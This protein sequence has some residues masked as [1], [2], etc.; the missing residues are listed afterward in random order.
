MSLCGSRGLFTAAAA[1]L[2]SLLLISTASAAP[3]LALGY[4]PKYNADFSHF[5]Y[6]DPAAVK[7]GGVTLGSFGSFDSLN[8]FILKGMAADGLNQLLF[9]TLMEQSLDEPFSQYGL[10]AEDVVLA[11]DRLSV[12]FRLRAEAQFSDGS[13]VTAEDVKFSFDTLKSDQAH[14]QYR[15]Y[16]ADIAAAE[17]ID[18]RTVRFKFTQVNP[19]L[20]LL[21]GQIP[22]FSRRWVGERDFS[23]LA[24]VEPIASGPYRVESFIIGKQITYRR[25]PN[26]W[27][28]D[29]PVRRGLYN[30]DTVQYKYYRDE[31]VALEAFK[32]GEFEFNL[33]SNSKKWATDYTGPRFSSGEI[34]LEEVAHHN[35]AG[36]QGFIFNLRKP[37]FQDQRVRQAIGLALDFEW[38]NQNLFYNQYQRCNSY[39]SNSD[40]AATE[41]PTAAELKL[42]E[43]FKSQLPAALFT[44]P[45]QPPTTTGVGGLRNNQRQALKL[46]EAAG[47][48][49][50]DGQ[51]KNS[52]GEPFVFEV[53]LVQKGFERIL[54]PFARNLEKLGIT[55]NYRTV[56]VA[57]YQQRIDSFD[58]EMVVGSFGQSQ[59]PGN[60]LMGMFHSSSAEEKG[61]RN[62]MGLKSPVV[63]ALVKAVIYAPDRAA[64]VTAVKALD[65]ALLYGDYLVPH[66][67]IGRHRI[68]WWDRFQQPAQRP[69][70]FNAESWVLMSWW[71]R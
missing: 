64:L 47:W 54:A 23:T 5:D 48:K 11:E 24:G 71:H 51:L 7:G 67:Y 22:I 42:L 15:F 63:D 62:L 29:L 45:W 10:L 30:F 8:P 27:G 3:A 4:T 66:W 2:S 31:T 50:V 61:S 36:M 21:A 68:A 56:D 40:L 59:S 34:K 57:L 28:R 20:H 6:A 69:L 16:Y 19:E 41:P 53:L 25:N 18:P 43:P 55:A 26:Y 46:L 33:E 60:E 52:Q 32:A 58:F 12:T 38:S 17:V 35:N 65:R 9:E 70:Y 44:T 1:A 39:F 14:P 13:P 37:L 49:M